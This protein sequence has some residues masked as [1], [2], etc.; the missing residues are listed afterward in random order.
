[1]Y[2]LITTCSWRVEVQLAEKKLELF[3][4]QGAQAGMGW[5]AALVHSRRNSAI[6]PMA[7]MTA[8]EMAILFVARAQDDRG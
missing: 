5:L 2:A 7:V 6:A 3:D 1:M 4:L 8:V